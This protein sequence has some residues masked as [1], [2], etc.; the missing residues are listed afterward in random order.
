MQ[1]KTAK[2]QDNNF[3][4]FNFIVVIQDQNDLR[5]LRDSI[6]V[7]V[8]S[9]DEHLGNIFKRVLNNHFGD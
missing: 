5:M 1:V 4:P 9:P 8:N 6:N 7:L 3:T 2:I